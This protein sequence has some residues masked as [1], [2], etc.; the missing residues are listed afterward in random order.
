MKTAVDL[1][2]GWGGTTLG[3]EQA[4]VRVRWAANH[5]ELAV[6]AHALNHPGTEHVCQ[7]LRQADWSKL[8]R[9]DMLLASPCCQGY[10]SASQPRR[11][12]FHDAMRATAWAVVDC[13][14]VTGPRAV[15]VENV[16]GFRR[17]QLYPLWRQ[18]LEVLGY[19]VSEHVLCAADFGVPQRRERLFVVGTRRPVKLSFPKARREPAFGPC[20]DWD[21]PG[22][23]PVSS[24]GRGAQKRIAAG[25][26]Q[27]GRRFLTQHVTGHRGVSLDEPIRTITT[28]R[29]W[30]VV[31][32]SR[33]RPLTVREYA[34]GMGFPEDYSW[35]SSASASAAMKG[36]GN[37]VPP[38]MAQ[39]VIERVAA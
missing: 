27:H 32:G 6:R 9:Y 22:W 33:Y 35:P 31:D 30:A 19:H 25:R 34:R 17:W 1:F 15:V 4:G 26:A 5:C 37:A 16:L 14:E 39:G 21:A 8:P 2:A 20:I 23:R 3:A 11:R 12:A 38:G 7:D 13:A 24:A 10:S 36:L 29:Q 18:A 28:K